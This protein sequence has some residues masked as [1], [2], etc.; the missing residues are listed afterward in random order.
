LR[1]LAFYRLEET[2]ET[3]AE[4]ADDV[5]K[6]GDVVG[7][8]GVQDFPAY[9]QYQHQNESKGDFP[10]VE[11]GERGM[12]YHHEDHAGSPKKKAGEKSAFSAPVTRAVTAIIM[13]RTRWNW[14]GLLR[15]IVMLLMWN[16][17]A[18]PSR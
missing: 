14:R 11:V 3:A 7:A 6:F 2:E 18:Q 16:S 4:T 17:P 9:I 15:A 5:G 1:R 10:F 12:E 8:E 13:R